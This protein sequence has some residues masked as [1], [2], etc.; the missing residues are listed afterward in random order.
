MMPNYVEE[1]NRN[2]FVRLGKLLS[3]EEIQWFRNDLLSRV[4][5]SKDDIVSQLFTPNQYYV[6]LLESQWLNSLI[7]TTLN[8]K[9]ILQDIYGLTNILNNQELTRTRFHRDMAWFP[10]KRT[11]VMVFI[12]LD[13][14]TNKNGPME[15]IPFS[16]L[17]ESMPSKEYLEKH[18]SQMMMQ[19]GEVVAMDA[20]IWHRASENNSKIARPVLL[21]KYS[22]AFIKQPKQLLSNFNNLSE[23]AKTRLGYY[24]SEDGWQSGNYIMENTDIL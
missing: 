17:F 6:N 22:L 9:A 10:H 2:G 15:F 24:V 7:D 18:K 23:M 12:A 16:H 1:M 5:Y 13:D 11:C 4:D 14:V 20:T 8:H 3:E 21:L 19:A